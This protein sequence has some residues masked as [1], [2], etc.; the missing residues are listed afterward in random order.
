VARRR[1]I[2]MQRDGGRC[3]GCGGDQF[4]EMHHI[5]P[6]LEFGSN[7]DDNLLILCRE[8]HHR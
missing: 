7:D 5:V 8:C 2:I 4:L 6:V 1:K 3:R